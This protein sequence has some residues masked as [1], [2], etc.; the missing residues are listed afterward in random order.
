MST[1][2]SRGN[3]IAVARLP[4]AGTCTRIIVSVLLVTA[5][6]VDSSR[7]SCGLALDRSSEPTSR[8]FWSLPSTSFAVAPIALTRSTLPVKSR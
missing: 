6:V 2:E 8:M 4:S 1:H 5:A 7:S 3:E